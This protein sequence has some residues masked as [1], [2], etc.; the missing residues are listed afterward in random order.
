[1]SFRLL[2]TKETIFCPHFCNVGSRECAH[3]CV[4]GAKAKEKRKTEHKMFPSVVSFSA[5]A[6]IASHIQGDSSMKQMFPGVAVVVVVVARER[7]TSSVGP[8][9]CG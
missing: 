5:N 1:M 8:H 4:S 9:Y 6:A 7:E 2:N 3:I